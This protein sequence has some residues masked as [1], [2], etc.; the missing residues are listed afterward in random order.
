M[1]A[2]G[3]AG[4]HYSPGAKARPPITNNAMQ[5][6]FK[7]L[8][9][10]VNVLFSFPSIFTAK[11]TRNEP[12]LSVADKAVGTFG[13]ELLYFVNFHLQS[14]ELGAKKLI[15]LGSYSAFALVTIF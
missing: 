5:I 12:Q 1:L 10:S 2:P 11:H 15:R 13:S 8:F 6:L 3:K 7:N 4:Q 14:A 9:V